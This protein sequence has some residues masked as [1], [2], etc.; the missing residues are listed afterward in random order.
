ML[1]GICRSASALLKQNL[2]Q[3]FIPLIMIQTWAL[4]SVWS[5]YV[6]V[7]EPAMRVQCKLPT[8][9]TVITWCSTSSLYLIGY[10]NLEIQNGYLLYSWPCSSM[11]TQT[12]LDMGM[13][14]LQGF[15]VYILL[16]IINRNPAYWEGSLWNTPLKHLCI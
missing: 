5:C 6:N 1:K 9:Y 3:W 13:P 2:R 14:L 11:E 8:I 7:N 16:D 12:T 15:V 4:N 10:P